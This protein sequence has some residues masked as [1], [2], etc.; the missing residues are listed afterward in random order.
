MRSTTMNSRIFC[1]ALMMSSTAWQYLD[2]LLK[3][4]REIMLKPDSANNYF[5]HSR[6]PQRLV[7]CKQPQSRLNSWGGRRSV[8][9]AS[10]QW[11]QHLMK[12]SIFCLIAMR[13]ISDLIGSTTSITWP[14]IRLAKA[15]H[16]SWVFPVHCSL[17]NCSRCPIFIFGIPALEVKR[18]W[19]SSFAFMRT[20][21][22]MRR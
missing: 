10:F 12:F 13:R 14:N 8:F 22:P 17:C 20:V 11:E 2:R 19:T 3:S 7:L 15:S 1:T 9:F 5:Q 16:A 6:E 21:R 18:T 4:A